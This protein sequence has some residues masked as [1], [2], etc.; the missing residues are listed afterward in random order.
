MRQIESRIDTG[1]EQF[2][3]NRAAYEELATTLRLR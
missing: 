1:G 3:T 2:A